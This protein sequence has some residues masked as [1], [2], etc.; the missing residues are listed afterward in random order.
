[1]HAPTGRSHARSVPTR[2]LRT[3]RLSAVAH[4][5][6]VSL[7]DPLDRLADVPRLHALIE[8]LLGAA[9]QH[10]THLDPSFVSD[11]GDDHTPFELSIS[12]CAG[13]APDLRVLAEP[14]GAT[15]S[16]RSNRDAALDVLARLAR[17]SGGSISLARL[18]RI[19]DLFL[20][21]DPRGAFAIWIAAGGAPGAPDVK[22][23]LS[24]EARGPEHAP[25]LVEEA[26]VRLGLGAAWPALSRTLLARGTDRDEL[27]YF[28]LD[29]SAHA[30]ARVKVYARHHDAT[31]D[32]AER[33]AS[34]A[35]DH[36][37]GDAA[38]LLRSV[39]GRERYDR[40]PLATCLAYDGA[41]PARPR[42]ATTY[43]PVND[44]APNDLVITQ[45]VEALL[46]RHA[47]DPAPYAAAARAC[48]RRP[49]EDGIGAQSYVAWK[50]RAG[51]PVVTVYFAAEAY[52]PGAIAHVAPP[53][54]PGGDAAALA[55]HVG[56]RSIVRHPFWRRLAREPVSLGAIALLLESAGVALTEGLARRVATTIARVES[57]RVRARLAALLHDEL[58]RGD[59]DDAH[60]HHFA[61]M[62]DAFAPHRLALPE[63]VRL[64]PARELAREIDALHLER[65]PYEGLGALLAS[66]CFGAEV[67]EALARE[68]A[69]Q[70]EV[71]PEHLA[72]MRVHRE[73]EE[74]HAGGAL[75][76][77]E[78]LPEARVADVARGADALE[79]A[80]FR[81][82]DG[83]YELCFGAP[84][85]GGDVA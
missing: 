81:F 28:S 51:A 32:D 12:L 44:Y 73:L 74:G 33:A 39:G 66:E 48:A 82:F 24:P 27:K 54:G 17:G 18:E 64:A 14:Q 84:A 21:E 77:I 31:I 65:P 49:L 34:A 61:R 36:R 69:R 45:R 71:G 9:A 76:L 20:P 23:Y 78:G 5:R 75:A 43:V 67:D 19:A 3:E 60:E 59:G 22:V 57:S 47:I 70:D 8:S 13:A 79:R 62:R 83:L 55:R 46:A 29:L 38:E 80:A 25:A 15:P 16:L 52:R 53:R 10:E 63:D 1:M 85:P 72:W 2:P 50:R 56:S 6:L 41:D 30:D 58:G 42:T 37:A 11:V 35:R 7:A 68:L 4:R 26:L 40:R